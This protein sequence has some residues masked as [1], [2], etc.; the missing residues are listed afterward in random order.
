[1]TCDD[2]LGYE[3]TWMIKLLS[4]AQATGVTLLLSHPR[5]CCVY[6]HIDLRHTDRRALSSQS[7]ILFS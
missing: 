1:M 5:I 7:G 2:T 4:H 6:T 3:L